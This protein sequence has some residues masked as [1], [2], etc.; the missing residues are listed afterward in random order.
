M[1]RRQLLTGLGGGA[2]ALALGLLFTPR[3]GIGGDRPEPLPPTGDDPF[4]LGVASG[5][6]TPDSV[7]LWTRLAPRPF[8]PLG[9]LPALDHAG[10]VTEHARPRPEPPEPHPAP[11][12]PP[13]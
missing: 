2:T 3:S 5:M 11:P 12:D 4:T 8:E 1:Q 7:V 6:P 13:L 9:G 10:E